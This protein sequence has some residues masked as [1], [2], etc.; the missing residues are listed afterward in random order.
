MSVHETLIDPRLAQ[1]PDLLRQGNEKS[2]LSVFRDASR[3]LHAPVRWASY[4]HT[5]LKVTPVTLPLHAGLTAKMLFNAQGCVQQPAQR[6]RLHQVALQ[7]G[8]QAAPYDGQ[9]ALSIFALAATTAQTPSQRDAVVLSMFTAAQTAL[10]ADN[11]SAAFVI[12]R[13]ATQSALRAGGK[14]AAFRAACNLA[15]SVSTP[16]GEWYRKRL[17]GL[18]L[19]LA[20]DKA[21]KRKLEAHYSRHTT[22]PV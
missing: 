9:A 21:E 10:K 3:R 22:A 7:S 1:L 4:F 13:Q 17:Q 14:P 6:E 20:P 19:R 18:S 15:E 11:P 8:I 16:D 12:A 5:A 2:A